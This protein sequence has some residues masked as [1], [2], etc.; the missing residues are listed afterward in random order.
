MMMRP[1]VGFIGVGKVGTTLARLLF[2]H[3]FI[4]QSVYSLSVNHA[5]G[6]A[7]LVGAK[8]AA[9]AGEV[10]A[11]SDLTF[12]TVPDDAIREVTT[13]VAT[14]ELAGKA[15]VHT[16]GVYEADVLDGL[17]A[18]GAMIGSLHP[19]F[20]FADIEQSVKG[21]PGAVFGM[22]A[23]S[24]RLHD[25]LNA[26]VSA[27]DG[28][29]LTITAGQKALYHSALVFASNYGV[30]LYAIAQRLL[31]HIGAEKE[32]SSTALNTLTAGMVRN[33]QAMGIPD[34]L[35]GPL[36]RGDIGTIETHLAAL[37]HLDP[38]L[39]DLYTQLALHTLPLAA[40]RGVD[41]GLI[42]ALLRKKMDDAA[43]HT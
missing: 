4:I 3:G 38:M 36:V 40:A 22:Q 23:E 34:A 31:L 37:Q 28:Q 13:A 18:R 35:T 15:V 10:I 33:L 7:R 39:V 26:I 21:L 25:W 16:S 5:E 6:L 2:A 32:V 8:G 24:P 20:P 42:E 29:A 17:A 43:N 9:S 14:T 12:L 41:T 30:I 19:I 1:A 27:L 11:S